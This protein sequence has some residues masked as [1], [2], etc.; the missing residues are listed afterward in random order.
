MLL[1][2]EK[3][4]QQQQGAAVGGCGDFTP[5]HAGISCAALAW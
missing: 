3:Q 2:K 5:A 4:Q 1:E